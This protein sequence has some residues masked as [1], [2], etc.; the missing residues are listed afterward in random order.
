MCQIKTI[1]KM[2]FDDP[3]LKV[4]KFSG[5][6]LRMLGVSFFIQEIRKYKT[7]KMFSKK[8]DSKDLS[9]T[10]ARD[11]KPGDL[12]RIRSKEQIL[13]TL[14]KD[15]MLEGCYFMDEMWQYCGS[16]YKVFKRVDYFFDERGAKFYKACNTVLLKDLYCSGKLAN[17][18]PRC[19]R[20]CYVFWKE[21]WLEKI[22]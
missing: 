18:M 4:K 14:D 15:N 17:L 8:E 5:T 9:F 21:D 10:P 3:T 1:T 2:G 16:Q 13:Q 22:E 6:T 20:N 11:L 7:K 12:V 19:D